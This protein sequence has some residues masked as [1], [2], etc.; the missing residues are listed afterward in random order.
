MLKNALILDCPYKVGQFIFR[1][2]IYLP[3]EINQ[4]PIHAIYSPQ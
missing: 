3:I 2:F 1:A 4:K